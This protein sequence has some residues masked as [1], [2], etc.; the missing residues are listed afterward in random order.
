MGGDIH[1]VSKYHAWKEV[2]LVRRHQGVGSAHLD[3]PDTESIGDW[4]A[5]MKTYRPSGSK[6]L[7]PLTKIKNKQAG[8]LPKKI[9]SF[10]SGRKY[11][12][13]MLHMLANLDTENGKGGMAC[14]V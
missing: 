3:L 6:A 1:V 14:V 10:R 11:F 12:C 4:I 7:N 2:N 8:L 5:F 9:A 13:E